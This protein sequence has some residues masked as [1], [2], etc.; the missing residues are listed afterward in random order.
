MTTTTTAR[1]SL[2]WIPDTLTYYPHQIEG[3]RE[4]ARLGSAICADEMGLGKS[5]QALTVFAVD[6]QAGWGSRLLVVAPATLKGNWYA[7]IME[8]TLFRDVVVLGQELR[9]DG[10]WKEGLSPTARRRQLARF[11]QET[12][13]GNPS[14][15]IVNYE[16]VIAHVGDLNTIGFDCIIYDEAHKLANPRSKRTKACMGLRAKRHLALT[17]SPML[18][19]VNDLWTLL[20]RVRPSEY[21]N[22]FAFQNRYCIFGGFK[23]KTIVGVQN[24]KELTK[25][26]NTV[27]VRRK[28]ADV[29][30]LPEKQH[31]TVTVPL[32][33]DQRDLYNTIREELYLPDADEASG[34]DIKNALTM[35]LRLKQV[36][37]T[38]ACF[39]PEYADKSY[40]LDRV[41]EDLYQLTDDGHKVVVFTQFRGVLAALQAR[42]EPTGL[43]IYALHGD[44]PNADRVPT[45]ARWTAHNGPAVVLAMHQVAGVGLNMTA[46]R[47]MLTVDKLFVPKLNEQSEDRIHRIGADRTQP[48][49]YREYL[50]ERTVEHRVE[51]IIKRKNRIFDS[52]VEDGNFRRKLY[53]ALLAES[54]PT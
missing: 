51:Q 21:P 43:P 27:M 34:E 29:L 7:E 44:V 9:D 15:L 49:Q 22:Y 46:A 2:D 48:V 41:E 45:V 16:Q 31:I 50:C 17:G 25:R 54:D 3:V 5:I 4:L 47:H 33:P 20:H 13:D 24:E 52:V 40:K 37:G 23:D 39:G 14:I 11:E 35:F 32:H 42:I 19:H 28:K 26:L 53:T 30:D 8:H 1:K 36:C 6:V 38:P 10:T 18:N 12:F